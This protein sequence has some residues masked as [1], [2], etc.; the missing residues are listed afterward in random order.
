MTRLE[1]LR[2]GDIEKIV[3]VIAPIV[4]W[5]FDEFA[6]C[7]G[8]EFY[9]DNERYGGCYAPFK[10]DEK[11]ECPRKIDRDLVY[12]QQIIEWLNEEEEP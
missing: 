11:Q 5:W 12:K 2:T 7:E 4:H 1:K 9:D 6:E 3:E 10:D 8:C